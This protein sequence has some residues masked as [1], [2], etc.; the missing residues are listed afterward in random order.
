MR[1]KTGVVEVGPKGLR[2]G[3]KKCTE[4]FLNGVVPGDAAVWHRSVS[5]GYHSNSGRYVGGA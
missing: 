2:M 4:E 3:K 5:K 1:K